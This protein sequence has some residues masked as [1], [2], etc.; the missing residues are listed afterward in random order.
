MPQADEAEKF[1]YVKLGRIDSLTWSDAE[2]VVFDCP[3]ALRH[4]YHNNG[5]LNLPDSISQED[6]Q[7]LTDGGTSESPPTDKC[8][9]CMNT[10]KEVYA[11]YEANKSHSDLRDAVLALCNFYRKYNE[12]VCA[13]VINVHL[14]M[15][16]YFAEH[17]N[18]DTITRRFCSLY[19]PPGSCEFE[20]EWVVNVDLGTKPDVITPSVPSILNE[21]AVIVHV[22]DL[23]YDPTYTLG[24]NAV[25]DAPTCCKEDQGRPTSPSDGAGYWGDYRNCDSPLQLVNNTLQH[26]KQHHQKIDYV[27]FTG[28]FVYHGMWE[29]TKE[30]HTQIITSIVRAFNETFQDTPV[31]FALG[32]HEP[33]Q[34]NAYAPLDVDTN[35]S[36]KWLFE[37]VSELWSPYIT[38][39]A[40]QTIL[41]GG[42][43]TVKPRDGF[44]VIVLN[45]IVCLNNNY[46]LAYDSRDPYNQLKWLAETLLLSEREGDKVHILYH[47]PT[48]MNNQWGSCLKI[49]GREF[50]KIVDRFENIVAA[51]FTGHT[52]YD[53][54]HVFYS[55]ENASRANGVSFNGG[56]GTPFI[57]VNP[58]YK[59]YTVDPASWNVVDSDMWIFNLTDANSKP[60]QNPDWFKLYSFR[61]EYRVANLL[62]AQLDSLAHRMAANHTLLQEYYRFY[63]KNADPSLAKGCDDA[64]LKERLCEIV[65]VESGDLSKCEQLDKEFDLVPNKH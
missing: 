3:C 54:F 22:S 10:V 65:T 51:H 25:C 17:A 33:I 38:E 59:T 1:I 7:P 49:W 27:Y 39:D 35:V 61:D 28:D 42:F 21:S 37:L 14:D 60:E 48:G 43:Y 30:Q 52:H 11:V 9:L 46:W 24:N 62:P 15:I 32:N 40:K 45:N 63:V 50:H 36:T 5:A 26:I 16:I 31:F 41:Q 4:M 8:T 19:L 57:D 56:S 55:T 58:N 18:N 12:V 29:S 47:V 64:C 2:V 44:R 34:A 13:G 20:D 53:E 23:H 6:N